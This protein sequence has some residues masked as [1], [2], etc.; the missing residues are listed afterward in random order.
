MKEITQTTINGYKFRKVTNHEWEK[1][2]WMVGKHFEDTNQ[3]LYVGD[4]I[5][6]IFRPSKRIKPI[7]FWVCERYQ[8]MGHRQFLDRKVANTRKEALEYLLKLARIS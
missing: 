6:I 7:R 4:I 1:E 8:K 2:R 3:T 5:S